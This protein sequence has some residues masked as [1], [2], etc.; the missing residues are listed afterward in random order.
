MNIY[1]A[2]DRTPYTYIITHL[3]TGKRYYGSRYSQYCRP[4]DLWFKYFTSSRAVH[5]LIEQDGRDAFKVSIRK[6][7]TDVA[8]CRSWESRFLHKIDARSNDKW[9]NAH[10]GGPD[11]YNIS[12]ASDIT[13]ERMSRVRKGM[14]KSDSMK[15]NAMWYYELKFEDGTTEYIKG[16][17]NVLQRLG[18][19]DWET[20]RVCIQKKNGFIPRAKAI[21]RRMPKSF[22][23]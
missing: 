9:I 11:F 16:K 3:P 5:E 6:T 4:D 7:F 21:I 8:E 14:P 2:Q 23:L 20:I 19:K 17:V 13:R 1:T 22:T 15:Q 12:T 10:N 18:R